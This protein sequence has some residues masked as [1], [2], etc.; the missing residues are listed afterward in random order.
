MLLDFHLPV[1]QGF[2]KIVFEI[3]VLIFLQNRLLTRIRIIH[4][5]GLPKTQV[6]TTDA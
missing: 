1:R 2:V 6:I 3:V 4:M 5:L